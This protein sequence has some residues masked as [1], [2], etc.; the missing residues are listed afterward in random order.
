[1]KS[2]L[3]VYNTL[4]RQM[5]RF[6]PLH[7]PSVGMYLC[8]PTVYGKAHLGHARSAINFDTIFRWLKYLGYRVRYV[9][10]ITDVGHLVSDADEGVDKI[11]QQARLEALEPMEV[12]QRYTNSYHQ[13]MTLLNV[14]PPSIEPIASGHIPEQIAMIQQIRYEYRYTEIILIHPHNMPVYIPGLCTS[15]GGISVARF[16]IFET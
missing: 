11:A 8:G 3:K 12:V 16:G 15:H 10:N 14:Q 6:V 13:D 4:T 2:Q 9:R 1:M 5:E 7:P